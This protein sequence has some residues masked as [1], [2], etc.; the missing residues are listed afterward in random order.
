MRH[1]LRASDLV[2]VATRGLRGHPLR[3]LLSALGIA[4]GVAAMV[5]VGGI[6][7]SSH[8]D[9]N[10]QLASL[11]TNLMRVYPAPDLQGTPTRLPASAPTMLGNIGPVTSRGAVAELP[12]IGVYRSP[13]VPSGNTN[14][15]SVTATGR[16]LLGVLRGRVAHGHWFTRANTAFPTVV[17]GSTAS[18]RL[19]VSTPGVR[20]W[21]DGHWCVVIGILDPL[22]LAPELNSAALVPA[23]AARRWFGADGTSTSVYLRAPDARV[24]SVSTVAPATASPEHPEYVGVDRPSD[25]LTAKLAANATFSHLLLGLA[26]VGL[27]VGGIG[28]GNTMIIAVIERRADIGLRRALGATRADVGLQFLT[29]SVLM[30]ATGG[31]VGVLVGYTVTGVYAHSQA[32][33]VSLPVWV[34]IG[35]VVVTTLVG[36]LAGLYP[37]VQASRQ[38]P[39]AA[40]AH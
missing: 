10:D 5:A 36:G 24:E 25:A 38:P 35:A 16:D 17:L 32:W 8:A 28:V 20:V 30:S 34:G 22:T 3:F 7:Q 27:I 19:A 11:G 29:E 37:A 18:R 12:D 31:A 15:L 4:V 14:S 1:R 39:T 40:L 2:R 21:I 33:Q 26:A 9:L 6:A 13:Y 23:I